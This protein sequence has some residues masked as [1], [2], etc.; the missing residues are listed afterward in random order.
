[1]IEIDTIWPSVF[2]VSLKVF[3]LKGKCCYMAKWV[4]S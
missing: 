3:K 4:N 1:M 2:G